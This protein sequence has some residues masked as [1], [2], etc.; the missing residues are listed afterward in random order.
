MI[1]AEALR[2]MYHYDTETGVFTRLARKKSGRPLKHQGRRHDRQYH[3]IN[4][5]GK[6]YLAHRLAWL[7]VHGEWPQYEIDHID[8]DKS[9][10]AI[11]NLRDVDHA[12][13]QQNWKGSRSGVKRNG[14]KWSSYIQVNRCQRYLGMFRTEEDAAAAYHTA[15]AAVISGLEAR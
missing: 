10:N 3:R 1:T 12:F 7:Y 14:N 9:N 4:I 13:N 11:V 5:D 2:A 15:K 6:M 8:G